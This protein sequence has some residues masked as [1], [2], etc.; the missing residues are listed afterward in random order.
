MM[1]LSC[2]GTLSSNCLLMLAP[3]DESPSDDSHDGR[4][5]NNALIGDALQSFNKSFPSVGLKRRHVASLW[6]LLAQDGQGRPE[7]GLDP[8]QTGAKP[9]GNQSPP[10][11]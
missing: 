2:P 3:A 6:R 5:G 8:F 11:I 9:P 4:D 1:T 10:A 7:S